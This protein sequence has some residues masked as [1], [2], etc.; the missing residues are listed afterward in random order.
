MQ[1]RN[2]KA[3]MV[4]NAQ[5]ARAGKHKSIMLRAGIFVVAAFVVL[6]M[7]FSAPF[8]AVSGDFA[9]GAFS[10]SAEFPSM[11]PGAPDVQQMRTAFLPIAATVA[12]PNPNELDMRKLTAMGILFVLAGVSFVTIWL[13]FKKHDFTSIGLVSCGVRLNC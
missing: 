4:H 9:N 10:V 13:F 8:V 5:D 12:E 1:V 11:E 2:N 3:N 6:T 7:I